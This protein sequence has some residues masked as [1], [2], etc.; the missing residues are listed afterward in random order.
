[1]AFQKQKGIAIAL[2]VDC[3]QFTYDMNRTLGICHAFD[4]DKALQEQKNDLLLAQDDRQDHFYRFDLMVPN[5]SRIREKGHL[6]SKTHDVH[7][8]REANYKLTE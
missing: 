1:M 4:K 3:R 5:P 7:N 6:L 2:M 8:L